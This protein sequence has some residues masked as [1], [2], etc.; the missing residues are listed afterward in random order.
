M[1]LIAR[2]RGSMLQTLEEEGGSGHSKY[3]AVQKEAGVV[4]I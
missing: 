2:G 1:T 4:S 3:W